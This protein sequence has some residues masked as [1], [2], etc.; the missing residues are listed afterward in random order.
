LETRAKVLKSSSGIVR[1]VVPGEGRIES[2]DGVRDYIG[3][4]DFSLLKWSLENPALPYETPWPVERTEF[5][6]PLYRRWL[7]MRRCYEGELLPP[8]VDID[9][10]WH[11]HILDTYAYTEHCDKIFGYYFHHFPYFGTRGPVDEQALQEA[12]AHT[13]L[14]YFEQFG[15]PLYQY[16]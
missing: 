5:V 10:F 8:S 14:R 1:Q 3:S 2:I 9:G 15:E 6:E 13:Q 11:V 12:F 7:F 4:L 16:E